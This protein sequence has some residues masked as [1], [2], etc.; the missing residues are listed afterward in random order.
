MHN[1]LMI[2]PPGAGKTMT[3]MRIPTILPPLD[4]KSRW[5]FRKFTV[6][7]DSFNYREQLMEERPFRCPHHTITMQGLVGGGLIPKPGEISRHTK[8]VLFLDELPEFKQNTI[9]ILRQPME[10]K[11]VRLVR[12]NGTY[13]YPADFILVVAMNPCKCGYYP[14]MQKCRCTAASLNDI[15][16]V[17]VSRS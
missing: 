12:V 13:E 10:E 16:T 2:G 6:Y 4:E 1:L 3:A 9:E 11:E 7:P 5:N 15:S 14:D 17:S 8:G